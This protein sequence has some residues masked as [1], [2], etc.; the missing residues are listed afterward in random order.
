VELINALDGHE[1]TT[2]EKEKLNEV[3]NDKHATN[4]KMRRKVGITEGKAGS[5]RKNK[6]DANTQDGATMKHHSIQGPQSDG[7]SASNLEHETETHNT[8]YY[9]DEEYQA[10][11]YTGA[12]R[13]RKKDMSNKMKNNWLLGMK[14][15]WAPTKQKTMFAKITV[16]RANMNMVRTHIHV[17][18]S[19][20]VMTMTDLTTHACRS[21]ANCMR[22]VFASWK[23]FSTTLRLALTLTLSTLDLYSLVLTPRQGTSP[24]KIPNAKSYLTV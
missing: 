4:K 13:T 3:S 5:N 12:K 9:W 19:C 6:K 21:T 20:I 10:Y 17:Y 24:K 16:N 1:N 18:I 7:N 14:R 23:T 11:V 22:R 15:T 2:K 8:E